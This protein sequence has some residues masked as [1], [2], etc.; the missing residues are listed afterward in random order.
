MSVVKLM[1][2]NLFEGAHMS[3]VQL[4]NFI[5]KSDVDILCLQEVDRKSHV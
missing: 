2:Y 3:Y 5:K 4:I 1:T